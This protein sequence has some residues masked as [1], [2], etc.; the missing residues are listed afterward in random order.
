MT[1][2]RPSDERELA[3][4]VAAAVAREEPLEIVAGGSKRGLGRPLQTP[5]TVDVAAFSGIRS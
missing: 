2:F 4:V 3:D 5:H 1:R